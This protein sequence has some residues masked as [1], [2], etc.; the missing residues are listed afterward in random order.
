MRSTGSGGWSGC[1]SP[2]QVDAPEIGLRPAP[3]REIT[4]MP[5]VLMAGV[6]TG[7]VPLDTAGRRLEEVGEMPPR[8]DP[9]LGERSSAAERELHEHV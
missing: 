5:D 9:L 7:I 6:S 2:I 4:T 8:S 1:C 3:A